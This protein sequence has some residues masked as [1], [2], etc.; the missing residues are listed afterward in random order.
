MHC[1]WPLHWGGCGAKPDGVL[2]LALVASHA[3]KTKCVKY[4]YYGCIALH[5]I[6]CTFQLRR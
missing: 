5:A 2:S 4:P 6:S 1:R 3:T